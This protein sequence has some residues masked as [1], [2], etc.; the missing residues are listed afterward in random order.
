MKIT[1]NTPDQLILANTPW[2]LGMAVI[3][4]VLILVGPGLVIA[5]EGIWQGWVFV[6][7]GVGL[8]CIAFAT[9]VRR[10]Q[11]ILDRPNDSIILRHRSVFGNKEVHHH[12][13]ELS[14]AALETTRG[15]KGGTLYRP[16]LILTKN[17]GAN[18]YPIV[19][20]YTNTSAPRRMVDA[21]NSWL[22]SHSPNA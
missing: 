9:F 10:T 21:I 3:F 20:S 1:R 22:D 12:L 8:G 13:S 5:F 4:F 17:M 15:S 2:L 18:S 6:L 16:A 11:L 14:K 7:A 19:P